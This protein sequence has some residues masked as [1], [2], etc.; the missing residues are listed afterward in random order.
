VGYLD[1]EQYG[2]VELSSFS[3]ETEYR[4][5]GVGSALL[6]RSLQE[7]FEKGTAQVKL[8]SLGDVMENAIRLYSRFGFRIY[9]EESKTGNYNLKRMVLTRDEMTRRFSTES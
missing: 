8:L 5:M 7:E 6:Q 9:E 1:E 3:V 4:C 2:F